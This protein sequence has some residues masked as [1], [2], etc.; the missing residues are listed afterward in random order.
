MAYVARK[1]GSG[2]TVDTGH[3]C[4]TECLTEG[5]STDVIVESYGVVREDDYDQTHE[6]CTDPCG[7]THQVQMSAD[8]ST[9]VKANYKWIAMKGSKYGTEEIDDVQQ[10]SVSAT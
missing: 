8:M 3:C 10:T 7:P 9:S 1:S 6:L 2:D 4:G 5:G